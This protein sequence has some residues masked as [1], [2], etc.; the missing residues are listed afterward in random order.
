MDGPAET[1]AAAVPNEQKRP[2]APQSA[3]TTG[4]TASLAAERRRPVKRLLSAIV[5]LAVLAFA[6]K[7]AF[8]WVTVGRFL[9]ETDNA[10]VEAD[11][12]V[13]AAETAG[14]VAR[15]L[16]TDNQPVAAGDVLVRIVDIDYKAK[17]AEAES[18]LASQTA[19]LAN[20]D[21]K[22]RWQESLI[23]AA[24]TAVTTA[25]SD[26]ARTSADYERYQRLHTSKVA[27]DQRYEVAKS[28][29][30]KAS[31]ALAKATAGLDAE[32]QQLAVVQTQRA[33]VEALI[34]QAQAQRDLARISFDRATIRSPVAG[35]VGNRGVQ[36][37][38]YVRPGTQLMVIV[39]VP[40]VHV[41]ANFKETQIANLRRG[42]PASI[43]IDAWPGVTLTGR[44]HSLAPASGSRFSLLP[45][46][47]A[48]GNFTK[49]VQ[50][51]PVRIALD[52]SPLDGKLRPGLSVIVD[53]DRR[54]AGDGD[55]A[56]LLVVPSVKA[57][58]ANMAPTKN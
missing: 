44:V 39:P 2:G 23:R 56:D 21:A 30:E 35:V 9:V 3:P 22:I 45:P 18:M 15:V 31:A 4:A 49:I 33:Q 20:V 12:S 46:E 10:Y 14:T 40:N 57:D 24:E 52:P 8:E 7:Y 5:G 54:A 25:K 37:G 41:V 17:V 48:T 19:A 36:V 32:R 50:R 16:V 11:T 26:V 6:L 47:N 53:I 51:V 28:D 29:A 42:Q 58:A 43:R 38:Q 55:R 27:S 1:P 34:A 13:V